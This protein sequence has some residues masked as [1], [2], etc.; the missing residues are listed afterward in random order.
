MCTILSP[1]L[2]NI[3]HYSLGV[4]KK[5][6]APIQPTGADRPAPLLQLTDEADAGDRSAKGILMPVQCDQRSWKSETDTCRT[7]RIPICTLLGFSS[8]SDLS[9]LFFSQVLVCLV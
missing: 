2:L 7:E 8:S 4:S 5:S 9:S 6:S 3:V 1:L